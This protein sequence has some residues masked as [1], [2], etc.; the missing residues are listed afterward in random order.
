M[1][2]LNFNSPKTESVAACL[3]HTIIAI[4]IDTYEITGYCPEEILVDDII[5][6]SGGDFKVTSIERRDHN[7]V[8]KNPEHKTRTFFKATCT[9]LTLKTFKD[10]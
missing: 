8:F 9:A 2:T 3:I 5:S 6:Y 1:K 7:G 10:E 4:G